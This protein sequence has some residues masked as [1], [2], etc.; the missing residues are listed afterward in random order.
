MIKAARQVYLP[1][2]LLWR[3]YRKWGLERRFIMKW[4]P[5]ELDLTADAIDAAKKREIKNILNSY[6]G[7]FDP[8]SEL[9]QNALDALESRIAVGDD[10]TPKLWIRIDLKDQSLS[11]TDNGIGFSKDEF[12]NFLAPTITFKKRENRGN[13]GVGATYLAYGFNF[14]QVGTKSPDYEFIGT[15]ANGREWVEVETEDSI[16]SRPTVTQDNEALH[17]PF[18]S[19]VRGATFTLKLVGDSIF[20]KDLSYQGANTAEEWSSILRIKTPL[21]G[22]YFEV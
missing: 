16:G 15:L 1:T 9:I 3:N 20:P 10:F 18:N 21:G 4:D 17:P 11:V 7:W 6:T 22:I 12:R 19:I 5:L 2:P 13:K 8:F 14:L